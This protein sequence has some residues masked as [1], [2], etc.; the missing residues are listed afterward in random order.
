M[1]DKKV[2]KMKD[3]PKEPDIKRLLRL[4]RKQA[5]NPRDK[6][7]AKLV[8]DESVKVNLSGLVI[9]EYEKILYGTSNLSSVERQQVQMLIDAVIDIKNNSNK[10]EYNGK[11]EM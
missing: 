9:K 2:N 5:M 1:V 3:V 6:K 4:Y 10:I 8:N 7:L 11:T